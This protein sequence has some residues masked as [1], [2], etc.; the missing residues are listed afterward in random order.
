MWEKI[1]RDNMLFLMIDFQEKFFKILKKDHVEDV[2]K[3]ILLL[4]RM[5]ERLGIPMMGT[6]H[7][8]KG[9]GHTDSRVLDV[10]TGDPITDKVI[11]SCCGDPS[12][13]DNLKNHGRPVVAVAGL[14]THICVLQTTMDLI[15][16]G[17]DVVVLMDAC[18]S[19]TTVKWRSGLEL[20]K[21]A[22]AVVM[23]TETLLFRLLGRAATPDFKYM[24]GLL[25]EVAD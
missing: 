17:Y 8:V 6:E 16:D 7:Y 14:E 21:D 5:F 1:V 25:K 3:N 13:R 11:F 12:F 24:V 19:S 10:W 9:L 15:R 2:R 22:G 23:T 20:M 18:L 4:I